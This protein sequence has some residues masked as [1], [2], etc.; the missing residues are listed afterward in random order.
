MTDR[1]DL[2]DRVVAL[3]TRLAHLD[4]IV[5][6][7]NDTITAQWAEINRLGRRCTELQDRLS[8]AETLAGPAPVQKPPHY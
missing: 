4:R 6:D 3:E 5:E 2:Q 7:L 8:E 1:A